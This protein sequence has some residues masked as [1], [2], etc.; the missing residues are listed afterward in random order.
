MDWGILGMGP[1]L[2]DGVPFAYKFVN[3]SLFVVRSY[4]YH[5]AIS[6]AQAPEGYRPW[7]RSVT[8]AGSLGD[9]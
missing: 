2:E 5:D 9:G 6:V 7:L 4:A 8:R 3:E 1:E